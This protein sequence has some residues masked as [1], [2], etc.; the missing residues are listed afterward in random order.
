MQSLVT[1]RA[2]L[3]RV[4]I[5]PRRRSIANSNSHQT[6]HLG[7]TS[8]AVRRQTR[9]LRVVDLSL[10]PATRGTMGTTIIKHQLLLLLQRL[11]KRL[12]PNK[13]IKRVK[14]RTIKGN[15]VTMGKITKDKPNLKL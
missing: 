10:D 7:S 14:I 4:R 15:K 13:A 12:M 5:T 11:D 9:R 6:L 2:P 8:S 3:R 1:S